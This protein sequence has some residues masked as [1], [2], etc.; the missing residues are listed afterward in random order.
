MR[1]I[2][3]NEMIPIP[4]PMKNSLLDDS[5]A[6]VFIK[7]PFILHMFFIVSQTVFN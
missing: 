5:C 7:S 6:I 3:D 4:S 1:K 2:L